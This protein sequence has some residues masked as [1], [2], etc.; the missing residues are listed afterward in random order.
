MPLRG[1]QHESLRGTRTEGRRR[2]GLLGRNLRLRAA[3]A[4][5]APS[6][7]TDASGVAADRSA[8]AH[9]TSDFTPGDRTARCRDSGHLAGFRYHDEPGYWNT[10]GDADRY[11]DSRADSFPRHV[12]ARSLQGRVRG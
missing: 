9:S 2:G 1:D 3:S 11:A 8:G 12:L 10:A 7:A 6:S 5:A 4:T